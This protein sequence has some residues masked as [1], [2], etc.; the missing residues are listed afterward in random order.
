MREFRVESYDYFLPPELIA[1]QPVE[2]KSAARLLVFERA[3]K[4]VTHTT[5]ASLCEVLPECEIVFN[6]TKVIKARLFGRKQSGGAVE[7][8]LNQPLGEGVFNAF[9]RGKV[10]VG[11]KIE[12]DLNLTAEVVELCEDGSRKL[13]F[14][15]TTNEL[16]SL[17]EKIGSV[18]LPPYIK[19][20]ATEQDE[21]WYQSYFA[22]Y[23]GAVAAP[24]ASLHFDE[25]MISKLRQNHEIHTLTLHVGAGTF[26]G[27]ECE[28]ITQHKMHSEFFSIPQSV[29]E[30]IASDAKILGVGTTVTRVVEF[31]TRAV[32]GLVEKSGEAGALRVDLGEILQSNSV[33]TNSLSLQKLLAQTSVSQNE[34]KA[35]QS[36]FCDL[37][38][39]PH[40]KPLRQN[41]LLTNFHLPKSTLIMLVAA[42]VGLDETMRLYEEA[43]SEGYRFY[44]Y[45]DAMLII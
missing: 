31:Y 41:F 45:G 9:V 35:L 19:R 33:L 37:F 36:G 7:V 40:N 18:P 34:L 2:P 24:T 23:S 8:L 28:E 13:A 5:F 25:E 44:S 16:F 1:T 32:L 20:E 29:A 3:S 14:N 27:V 6:D 43:V 30:L 4:R 26:K 12:F 38:L 42:F 21:S 39:H 10:K 17:C 22:K 11:V 15:C